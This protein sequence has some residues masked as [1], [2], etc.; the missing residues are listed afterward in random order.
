MGFF[1]NLGKSLKNV[2]KMVSLKNVVKVATG[3]AGDLGKELATRVIA[4]HI[5]TSAPVV[6][7]IEETAPLIKLTKPTASL[8]N[9]VDQ[10]AVEL[11]MRQ[12]PN[13]KDVLQG[14]LS[15]AL[16]G[17]GTTLATGKDVANIGADLAD[18]TITAWF[19]KHWLKVVG[20]IVVVTGFII[21]IVK[22]AKPKSKY[23]YKR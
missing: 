15:G 14:A 3:Q 11:A 8:S 10:T 5:K 17:A 12:N 18:N 4:P 6:E 21:L 2:T 16:Q 19:K 22:M 20:G 13:L 9:Q 7:Y 23:G 1:K